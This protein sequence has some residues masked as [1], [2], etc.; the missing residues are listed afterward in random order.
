MGPGQSR[1]VR[2]GLTGSANSQFAHRVIPRVLKRVFPFD[3]IVHLWLQCK[4]SPGIQL[5]HPLGF[6][7]L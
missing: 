4:V 5:I 3:K 2:Q 6:E 7:R 1:V